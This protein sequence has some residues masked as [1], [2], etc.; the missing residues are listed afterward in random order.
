MVTGMDLLVDRLFTY[1]YHLAGKGVG[2][3]LTRKQLTAELNS[4][5]SPTFR[6]AVAWAL[7]SGVIAERRE[8]NNSRL[9]V[10]YII[11]SEAI[12]AAL[13]D[14]RTSHDTTPL[15]L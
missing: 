10:F 2:V 9:K 14:R 12:E 1:L 7:Q 15:P 11:T 3:M 5:W 6:Q 8:Y 4:T 13:E